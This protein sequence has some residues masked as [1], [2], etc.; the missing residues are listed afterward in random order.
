MAKISSSYISIDTKMVF[1]FSIKSWLACIFFIRASLFCSYTDF[2]TQLGTAII[3]AYTLMPSVKFAILF[4]QL[5]K[6]LSLFA[7]LS[8]LFQISHFDAKSRPPKL[9]NGHTSKNTFFWT[10]TFVRIILIKSVRIV[11]IHIKLNLLFRMIECLFI[12]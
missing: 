1:V 10:H 11:S 12:M 2:S 4:R 8:F 9:F 3:H 5:K 6:P 7:D